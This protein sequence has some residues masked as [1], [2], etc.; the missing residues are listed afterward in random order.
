M[1]AVD[2]SGSEEMEGVVL[3][4]LQSMLS[5]AISLNKSKSCTPAEETKYWQSLLNKAYSV[6]DK[7]EIIILSIL[8]MVFRA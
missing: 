5:Y 4:L 2:V 7:V 6:V 3:K 1:S 8:M